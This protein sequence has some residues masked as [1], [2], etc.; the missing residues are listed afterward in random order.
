MFVHMKRYVDDIYILSCH[1]SQH[2]HLL[3]IPSYNNFYFTEN[4]NY[5]NSGKSEPHNNLIGKI[6][7]IGSFTVPETGNYIIA[8]ACASRSNYADNHPAV[9]AQFYLY[10][11]ST[12]LA[13]HKTNA[14][15]A[16]GWGFVSDSIQMSCNKGEIIRTNWQNNDS[17]YK[18]AVYIFKF[19]L[20][21]IFNFD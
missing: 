15:N 12:L 11:G 18:S 19:G 3:Y 2:L 20:V 7:S 1:S 16:Y 17:S 6:N 5:Y 21:L 10:C 9:Y 14:N 8:Y 4:K 13:T